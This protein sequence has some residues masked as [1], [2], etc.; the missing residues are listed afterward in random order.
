MP[1][2]PHRHFTISENNFKKEHDEKN[3]LKR[4]LKMLTDDA[5][6]T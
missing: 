6:L 1:K 3:V 2:A 4:V 5:D